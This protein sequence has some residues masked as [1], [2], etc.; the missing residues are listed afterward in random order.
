MRSTYDTFIRV[1]GNM[2]LNTI[3]NCQVDKV[4]VC[5]R[6]KHPEGN[7]RCNDQWYVSIISFQVESYLI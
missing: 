3:I 5:K 6:Q 7:P 1:L 4:V 2:Y